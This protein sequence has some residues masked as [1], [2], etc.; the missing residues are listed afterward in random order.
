M[1]TSSFLTCSFQ[2]IGFPSEWGEVVNSEVAIFLD[3]FQFIG[4]PSEW[5]EGRA[6]R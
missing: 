1:L 4:F 6:R 2:F 5:G 3:G